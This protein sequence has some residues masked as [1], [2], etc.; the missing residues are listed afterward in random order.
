M[1][2][3]DPIELGER[4]AEAWAFEMTEGLPAGWLRCACGKVAPENQFETLSSDPW[5]RPFC[6]GCQEGAERARPPNHA[7]TPEPAGPER[8]GEGG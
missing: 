1:R 5:A 6:P 7:D 8:E 2:I 4:R 3:P